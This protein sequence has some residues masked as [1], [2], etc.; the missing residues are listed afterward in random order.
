MATQRGRRRKQSR[1]DH[2]ADL[3]EQLCE[4]RAWSSYDLAA[5]TER[6]AEARDDGRF[7][8]SRRTIDRIYGEGAVPSA[9]VKCGIALAL[10]L[11]P[12]QIWGPGAI[13]LMHQQAHRVA[14]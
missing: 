9:R 1:D 3:I 13:P 6:V 5:A 14:A 11:A 2:A 4:A 7:A 12:W 10:D 8:V